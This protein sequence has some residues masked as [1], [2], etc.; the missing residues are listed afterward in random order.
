M[1]KQLRNR[2]FAAIDMISLTLAAYLCFVLQAESFLLGE[3][4][5]A[6]VYL[7]IITIV[8]MPMIFYYNKI[9][10]FYWPYASVSELFSLI[11][12]VSIAMIGIGIILVLAGFIAHTTLP[13]ISFSML[14]VFFL[15]ALPAVALPR[16]AVRMYEQAAPPVSE[17]QRH[18][19]G[20]QEPVRSIVMGAGGAGQLVVREL[21]QQRSSNV[22]VVGFLDDDPAKHGLLIH[23]IKVF[24]DRYA[25]A[26]VVQEHT[27]QQVIIA[28]PSAPGKEIRAILDLCKSVG[29][30]TKVVPGMPEIVDGKVKVSQLR[31]VQIE[32]LLRRKAV[33]TD[34][35]AVK[36]L[37]EGK[38]VLVTGAGGSIGSELCRQVLRCK[39]AKLILLGRGENSIFELYNELKHELQ[40]TEL[41]SHEVLHP[42]I[43]DIRF[44]TRMKQTFADCKPDVV[45]HAAAHKHVPLM[46]RSPAEAII[47]NVLG[48]RN[49]VNAALETNVRHFVMISTDKAV[50]PTSIMGASKRVAELLVQ[51]A[52]RISGRPYATVRFGNVLGSRGSVVLSFKKQIARGGPVTVTHPEMQRYFMTIPE[53][54]QLVL[55]SAVLSEG[56][57]VY[58]LDMGEQIKI[59]DLA[60]DLIRLSG[61]EVGRDI[62]ITFTGIRPGEKLYEELF[63]PGETFDRTR[64]EKI[65][66]AANSSNY[67]PLH[68]VEWVETLVQAAM[69]DDPATILEML[70]TLIPQ[71]QIKQVVEYQRERACEEA[72]KVKTTQ[73]QQPTSQE[74]EP[75]RE[76]IRGGDTRLSWAV[77][78]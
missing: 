5:L 67:V 61:L 64:H 22:E 77:G 31:D 17:K 18:Q 72:M 6:F 56:G 39:P 50:H 24:G 13:T 23:G 4:L 36:N 48:T 65:F 27:I 71:H 15:L 55:Q 33:Q 49:L 54:V 44:G 76:R 25:L 78:Q 7:T 60:H 58:T 62:D 51:K 63:M 21:L 2:H 20:N 9:Y 26:S 10:R 16:L 28:M 38:R 52:A 30:K 66:V 59:V 43:A 12:S 40:E 74:E 42:I 75:L 37:I 47:N 70:N 68:L 35:Q 8:I 46:E 45:F 32:D 1:M 34:I 41:Q 69:K 19:P 11:R 73:Q 14:V 29:V 57:E 3:Y 53:A